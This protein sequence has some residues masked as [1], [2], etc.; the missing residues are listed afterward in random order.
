MSAVEVE[1]L[2]DGAFAGSVANV[3]DYSVEESGSPLALTDL[4]AGVGGINFQ[5]L[6]EPGFDGSILLS[7]QPFDL[8]DPYSGTQRGVIDDASVLNEYTLDVTASTA[9]LPLVSRRDAD[10]FTGTLGGALTYYFS[11]CG[12]TEG[13]QFESAVASKPVTL[14]GWSADV[15]TQI[16]KLEAIHQFEVADVAGRIVVRSL[17]QR[18]IDVRKYTQSRLRYGRGGASHK[19]EVEFYNNTFATD[20]QVYPD[21]E[22]KVPDRQII[23]VDAGETVTT[24]YEVS[25][26]VTE[27]H[28]PTHILHLPWN[29]TSTTSVY[30]VVDKDGNAVNQFD[31]VNGGGEVTFAI[32]ED[33]KSIDVTV[34]GMINQARAPYRLASSSEDRE[35]QFAALYIAADGIAFKP[36]RISANTGASLADAPVDSVTRIEEPLIS[37]REEAVN[38]LSQAVFDN[39]GFSQELEVTATEIN[40]RGETGQPIG[41]TFAEWDSSNSGITFAA[42]DT[43]QA[44]KTFEQYDALLAQPYAELFSNQAF[45]GVGGA[46]IRHRDSIYRVR[47]AT[48]SPASHQMSAENDFLFSDWEAD[49]T[50]IT[51]GAFDELWAGKTF[52]QHAR[53]P[54]A[55]GGN[56]QTIR[57]NLF[58]QPRFGNAWAYT[59]SSA[60]TGDGYVQITV[61]ATAPTS[62]WVVPT[63][64]FPYA[65]GERFSGA[66]LVNNTG[67]S[68]FS[69][70]A[71]VWNGL[72]YSYG[73]T[74]TIAPGQTKRVTIEGLTYSGG[75]GYQFRLH[76]T[77][78]LPGAMATISQPI[79]EKAATVGAFFDG[80]TPASGP[81]IRNLWTGP[82]NNSPSIQQ[83]FIPRVS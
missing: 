42:F 62:N 50:D 33:K 29:T 47:S 18:N 59:S 36:E 12:I 70:R 54:L 26:W 58:D 14:P 55:K 76:A 22:T 39:C 19:V 21:P 71:A 69:V 68:E 77:S 57:R 23:S 4:S 81:Y 43:A 16:K 80:S 74:V 35:Y 25:M 72:A 64:F 7:G 51:F 28:Q 1:I 56:W 79:A 37:T 6:E 31:W 52:E 3:T 38:V 34:R 65:A 45:G 24:N 40:R 75:D 48:S 8:R 10:A 60:V 53:M 20:K 44:G 9:M 73:D 61:G 78:I 66:Y 13:F 82:V 27:V 63:Q 67:S 30:S 83:E 32:G 41:P 46:R 2:G 15:W 17:R 49:Q 5:V 11:L